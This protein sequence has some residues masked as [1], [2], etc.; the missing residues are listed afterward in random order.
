MEKP[1]VYLYSIFT[2]EKV[3]RAALGLGATGAISKMYTIRALSE[4]LK[5][6][7]TSP[8]TPAYVFSGGE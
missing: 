8:V 2:N 4:E 6:V 5:T 7:L 3:K 1:K